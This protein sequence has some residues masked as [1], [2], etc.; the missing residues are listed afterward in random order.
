MSGPTSITIENLK[1]PFAGESQT[2]HRHMA[3]ER[4]REWFEQAARLFREAAEA[5]TVHPLNNFHLMNELKPR[6]D[7]WV[8]A[9]ADETF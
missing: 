5:E 3:F 9:L 7:K 8:T 2:N 1:N 6:A 4:Q